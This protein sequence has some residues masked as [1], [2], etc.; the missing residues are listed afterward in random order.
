MGFERREQDLLKTR[1][2]EALESKPIP[3]P[4][5]MKWSDVLAILHGNLPSRAT[6]LVETP[7]VTSDLF[8]DAMLECII[9]MVAIKFRR[10]SE[11]E[12][13]VGVF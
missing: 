11:M 9:D 13:V 4:S 7:N 8:T 2:Q 1:L 12:V 10:L 3:S 6:P 5:A